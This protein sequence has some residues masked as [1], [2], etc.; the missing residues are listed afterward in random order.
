MALPTLLILPSLEGGDAIVASENLDG[1][2][3][4]RV[5]TDQF[6]SLHV[7]DPIIV[8]PGQ[9]VRIFE[10]ELPKAG[11]TQQLKMARFAREDDI[12]NNADD[13]HFA[14]SDG[15]P[16]HLAV[17][18]KDVMNRVLETFGVLRPKAIFADYDLLIGKEALRVIDRAVKPG[19]A[20][21]DLDWTDEVLETLIDIDLAKRF[22][23][24]V[25]EDRGLNL[26]QGDYR[27]RSNLNLPKVPMV[28]FGALAAAAALALFIWTGI[29]DRAALSQAKD[30]RAQT[31]SDYAL[32][33]GDRA[34]SNPGRAAVR[35]LQSGP[36]TP[37]GFL[38]LS[39]VLFTGL[40]N[41]D[42]MRVDQLRYN[43]EDGVLRL[44]LI[45]P[46]FDAASRVETAIAD[47][48][49]TLVT[50]GVR[51]QDGTFVGEATLTLGGSS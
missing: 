17:V 1:Y 23:E 24:G 45:Y 25:Q 20:A 31:A 8:L 46:S 41:F 36:A 28:R 3:A 37:T 10:T 21:L 38:D 43:A 51:E 11:R 30:L 50:G 2:A 13:L 7:S 33:T 15:Q 6:A 48:G 26:L 29:Q 9:W 34:P 27:A 16:P 22:A 39:A 18:D 40:S 4:R 14:L 44:R 49:G 42:D 19:R 47:V 32:L 5:G 35:A 12:A